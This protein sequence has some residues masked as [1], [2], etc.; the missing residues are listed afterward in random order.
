MKILDEIICCFC[1]HNVVTV[2]IYYLRNF[3][4]NILQ[5]SANTSAVNDLYD[6]SLTWKVMLYYIDH[7]YDFQIREIG[8]G[9]HKLTIYTMVNLVTGCKMASNYH[10]IAN[11]SERRTY[12]GR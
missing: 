7:I 12:C 10:L 5:H 2:V 8:C 9:S 11:H 1:R 3:G 4:S 6:K